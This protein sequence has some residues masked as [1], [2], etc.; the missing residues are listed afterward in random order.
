[1]RALLH[2]VALLHHQNVV[3]VLNGAKA[4]RH[5]DAGA[6]LHITL[7]GLLY[8][9]L[10]FGVEGGGGF[11]Q[12]KNGRIAQNG[13]GN[14]NAL[15]LPAAEFAAALAHVGLVAAGQALYK[16]V[17]ESGFG[18]GF[19]LR[20]RGV[21]QAKNDVVFDGIVEQNAVLRHQGK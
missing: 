3:G 11:V 13:S 10:R 17:G 19:Y 12:N 8:V 20:L 1:M 15:P 7:Q 14:A 21:G 6:V 4:V 9:L 2:N 5:H 16:I 18:G